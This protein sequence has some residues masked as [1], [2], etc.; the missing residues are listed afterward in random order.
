M[1]PNASVLNSINVNASLVEELVGCLLSC[2][3]GLSCSL[4][5]K[6]ISPSTTCPNHY[7]GVFLDV[8]S[9]TNYPGYVDDTSRFVW[10]FLA[11]RTSVTSESSGSSCL[12]ECSVA[13][14]IC[15]GRGGNA[16]SKGRCVVSS[17]RYYLAS[18]HFIS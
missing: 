13:G 8:P 12:G 14:E 16:E 15:I 5:K 17:T 11:D 6:Y 18:F 7:V 2:E 3:P 10:N 9:N 1:G 4:V